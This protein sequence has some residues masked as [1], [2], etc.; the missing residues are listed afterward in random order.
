MSLLLRMA[1]FDN[2][3]FFAYPMRQSANTVAPNAR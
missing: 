2:I 3:G 1:G